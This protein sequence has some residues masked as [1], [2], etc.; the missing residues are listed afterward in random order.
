MTEQHIHYAPTMNDGALSP[1]WWSKVVQP[2]ET[3][4]IVSNHMKKISLV[5]KKV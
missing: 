1:N 2:M 3:G 4:L 5:R